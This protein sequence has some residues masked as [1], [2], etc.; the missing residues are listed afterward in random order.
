VDPLEFLS[1]YLNLEMLTKSARFARVRS[2]DTLLICM[3][4]PL[5]LGGKS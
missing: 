4:L 1:K 3:S 2:L 5:A